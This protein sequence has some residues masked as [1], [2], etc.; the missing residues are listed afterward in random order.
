MWRFLFYLLQEEYDFRENPYTN[1]HTT[2][3]ARCPKRESEGAVDMPIHEPQMYSVSIDDLRKLFNHS[4]QTGM[5]MVDE[6][7]KLMQAYRSDLKGF[8]LFSG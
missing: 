6:D 7:E 3:T 5:L 8:R 1:L 4:I 2:D